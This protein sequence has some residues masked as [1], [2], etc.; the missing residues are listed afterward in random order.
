MVIWFF[1]FLLALVTSVL[2]YLTNPIVVLFS[3]AN[4]ELPGFLKLWQTWDNSCN[5]SELKECAPEC[6]R[7]DWDAHFVEYYGT[8]P[9]LE[10]VNR[11][12]WF[13]TCVNDNWTIKE[14]I[15]LYLCRC[16]WLYRNNAYGWAF[17]PLGVTVSPFFDFKASENTLFVK[18]VYA[19]GLWGAWMYKN[20]APIFKAFGYVVH[21]NNLLGWKIDTS[22]TVD[23][24]AMVAIRIAFYVEKEADR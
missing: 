20:T 18:E 24:R 3:N 1:Y 14:R 21:W 13:T 7:F 12:R 6:I 4:G 22:A 11:K 23:T 17:Y 19:P 2:C 15:K 9:E 10:A 5:P 8:T 16:Y